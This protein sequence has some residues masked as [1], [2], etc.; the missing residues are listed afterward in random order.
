MKQKMNIVR[1]MTLV[2][3][4]SLVTKSIGGLP[5]WVFTIPTVMLGFVLTIR[6]WLPAGFIIGAAAGFMVWF[7]TGLYYGVSP[8]SGVLHKVGALFSVPAFVVVVISG[9]IGGVLTGLSLYSGKCIARLI[10]S[11]TSVSA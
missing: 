10:S 9:L 8:A 1:S 11:S 2:L 5:W 7:G 6:K 4:L 3:V